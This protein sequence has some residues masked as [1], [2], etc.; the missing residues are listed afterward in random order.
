M[1]YNSTHI[2]YIVYNAQIFYFK[3]MFN[4]L[5]ICLHAVANNTEQERVYDG[6]MGSCP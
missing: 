3:N 5:R 1:L 4:I 6:H 2:Y